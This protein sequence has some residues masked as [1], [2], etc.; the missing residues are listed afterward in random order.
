MFDKKFITK[1]TETI[2]TTLESGEKI[3]RE[4]LARKMF[5]EQTDKANVLVLANALGAAFMLGEFPEYRCVKQL[6]IV[7]AGYQTA[8]EDPEKA[9]KA[10]A[11]KAAKVAKLQAELA[12]LTA[13]ATAS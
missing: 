2:K 9:A 7:P 10:E 3:T 12:K 4:S 13:T 11:K 6:G 5:P 1:A 8:K